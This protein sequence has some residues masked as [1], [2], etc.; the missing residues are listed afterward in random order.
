MIDRTD[1]EKIGQDVGEMII[2]PEAMEVYETVSY[3]TGEHGAMLVFHAQGQKINIAISE[4]DLS[5]L[6]VALTEI[7]TAI[8]H[9]NKPTNTT[10]IN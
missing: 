1:N 8:A 10:G 5:I 7:Q 6:F 4:T 3:P 2:Y 9:A